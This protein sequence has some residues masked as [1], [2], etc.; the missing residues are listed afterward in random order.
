MDPIGK[1]VIPNKS[2]PGPETEKPQQEPVC[3]LRYFLVSPYLTSD[4]MVAV[5][6]ASKMVPSEACLLVSMPLCN[7]LPAVGSESSDFLLI[8]RIEQE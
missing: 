3:N 4:I 8:Y 1:K 5:W 6:E 2:P 7:P